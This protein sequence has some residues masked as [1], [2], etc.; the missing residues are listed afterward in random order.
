L[1]KESVVVLVIGTP[2][3]VQD[4]AC[5]TQLSPTCM[6]T[7]TGVLHSIP[8]RS[9]QST[10]IN[11]VLSMV[12]TVLSSFDAQVKRP[13]GMI[14]QFREALRQTQIG[15]YSLCEKRI[16]GPTFDVLD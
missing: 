6:I 4:I 12:R 3:S 8:H 16:E 1:T 7:F 14:L 10:I 2:L 15:Q 13:G 9:Q 5:C 11:N